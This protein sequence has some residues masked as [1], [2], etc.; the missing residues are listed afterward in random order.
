M[1]IAKKDFE[2]DKSGPFIIEPTKGTS[3]SY[4]FGMSHQEV[5]SLRAD[6]FTV[7]DDTCLEQPTCDADSKYRTF[8]GSCNN[9]AAPLQGKAFTTFRR[10]LE[11]D[12]SDGNWLEID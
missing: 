5:R 1:I 9:V 7:I 3:A 10:L 8:D 11:P 12:Y 6:E 4:S 2:I